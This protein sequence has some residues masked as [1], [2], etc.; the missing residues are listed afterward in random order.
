MNCCTTSIE[1]GCKGVGAAAADGTG[2]GTCI[3]GWLVSEC[4]GEL[5]ETF[6]E[7]GGEEVCVGTGVGLSLGCLLGIGVGLGLGIVGEIVGKRV[8]SAVGTGVGLSLG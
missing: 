6:L 2:L 1:I 5:V 7:G 4:D 8:G 3:K